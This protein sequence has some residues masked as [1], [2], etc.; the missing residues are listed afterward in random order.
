LLTPQQPHALRRLVRY[1]G[2]FDRHRRIAVGIAVAAILLVSLSFAPLVRT[3]AAN[4][5][6]ARG[7]VLTI[8]RVWPG[9]MSI[10]LADATVT[11]EGLPGARAEF[12]HIQLLVTPWL[13]LRGVIVDDGELTLEGSADSLREQIQAWR[14]RHRAPGSAGGGSSGSGLSIDANAIDVTW[15]ADAA[16]ATPQT[17]T[18]I[19]FER[20]GGRARAAFA[21][22]RVESPAGAV[23]LGDAA[24]EFGSGAEGLVLESARVAQLLGRVTVAVSED[25]PA[26]E[27]NAV[28]TPTPPAASDFDDEEPAD[29]KDLADPKDLADAKDLTD[30]KA[31]GKSP[32][33]TLADRLAPLADQSWPRRR[34]Q[35]DVL[36]KLLRERVGDHARVDIAKIQLEVTHG[37]SVLNFGPAPLTFERQGAVASMAFLPPAEKGGKQLTLNGRLPLDAGVIE[38]NVEGGPISLST[39]GVREGDFGL[40]DVK[41]S[42]LTLST[43]VELSPEGA[44]DIAASG[45]LER[46]SIEQAALAPEPLRDMNLNW[47]GQVRLDLGKRRFAIEDGSVGVSDVRVTVAGSIEASE[48]DVRV[49]LLVE[50]PK[51]SC[52]DLL[53][54]APAALLPQLQGLRLGGTFALH[55]R[56]A[57]DTSHLDATEVEWE[58]DNRCKV[59]TTPQ[60]IDPKNFREPFQHFVVE[61]DGRA[62]EFTTGPTTD[63]WVSLN[64]ITPNMETGLIV[65]EDS[66]FFKHNGFDNKAI[67]DSILSNLKKGHFVRGASTLSMQLAKN[68]YLGREKTLS[69]KLQEAAFT[70]LLEER[71]SKEDILEL[72]LN[73]VEFGPGI[74]GIRN[75]AMHYF[76][77]HPAELSLAQAMFFAS[78]LPNPKAN[79]FQPDGT[80]K[81]RWERHLQYLMRVARKINRIG[82]DELE[83][84]M[85]EHLV[86]GQAHPETSSDFLFGTPL[87]DVNEG[88]GGNGG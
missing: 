87:Y 51:T 84:G 15:R 46:L 71:L 88:A 3:I 79:H 45:R 70:L 43:H 82:D 61:P 6:A 68:L 55:S 60:D 19:S 47:S 13:S 81:P 38:L 54:A 24:A 33:K 30:P 44:L 1:W 9:W 65:C 28:A 21:S 16:D 72:Y 73:V 27:A 34:E 67:R 20:K 80:L 26:A 32:Q 2:E 41:R 11:L 22:A 49:G 66:R 50:I 86:F 75:A 8:E 40:L 77:S 37:A 63:Q 64:E 62:T 57:L 76:N 31:A 23:T 69:R 36:R 56:V 7:L 58:F 74:Y 52:Q 85:N 42:E 39:L 17:I 18:G 14:A 29:A 78:I 35:I 48:T 10:H 5:A 4:K 25:A 83:A 12:A 53:V 59:L